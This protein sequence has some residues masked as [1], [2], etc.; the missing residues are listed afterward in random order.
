MGFS[1][2]SDERRATSRS[3]EMPVARV[4]LPLGTH[5][6]CAKRNSRPALVGRSVDN[7]GEAA[8]QPAWAAGGT[9]ESRAWLV[10]EPRGSMPSAAPPTT[11][12]PAPGRVVL[13]AGL[14]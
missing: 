9:V 2:P 10:R 3:Y 14:Q 13:L 11:V 6:L 12:G 7:D 4:R 8:A 5:C 1:K